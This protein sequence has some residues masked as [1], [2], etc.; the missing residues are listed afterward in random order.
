MVSTSSYMKNPKRIAP[1]AIIDNLAVIGD[2]RHREAQGRSVTRF[3]TGEPLSGAGHDYVSTLQFLVSYGGSTA[4]FNAYRRELERLLQWSWHVQ[5]TSV[6]LLTRDDI[7]DF[8]RFTIDP[9]VAWIGTKN[10]AR[11]I[12]R[13]G[14]RVPNPDWRPFVASV[15]KAEFRSGEA[16]DRKAYTPSQAAVRATFA[17]LSSFYDYLAQESLVVANPV[18]LYGRRASFSAEITTRRW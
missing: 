5:K 12:R 18:A 10:V 16:P 17:V 2:R 11:F 4:T 8:I 3:F 15:S 9:P 13:E 1:T 6:R 7:A 14:E